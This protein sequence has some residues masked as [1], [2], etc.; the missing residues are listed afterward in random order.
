MRTKSYSA[1]IQFLAITLLFCG[2]AFAGD[3]HDFTSDGCSLFPDGN[4]KDRGLWCQC[5]LVHDIAY[6]QG[7]TKEDR[8]HADE[9][10]RDCVLERTRNKALAN[11]I[12]KGV[13]GAAIPHSPPGIAGD[14]GGTTARD[15]LHSRIRKSGRSLRS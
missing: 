1:I 14:T 6:W 15:M 9:A 3:I 13:R 11:M 8:K 4:I 5:C 10:L 7:G 12:H 2:F